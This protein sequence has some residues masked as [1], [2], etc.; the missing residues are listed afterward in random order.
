MKVGDIMKMGSDNSIVLSG[1]T[2]EQT[3]FEMCRK[4]VGGVSVVDKN[5]KLL[6]IFTDGDLRRCLQ[7]HGGMLSEEII[8]NL[9]MRNPITLNCNQLIW[10]AINETISKHSVS[11]FPV[12]D[13]NEKIVGTLCMIDV[14]KS[15]L[16]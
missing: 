2:L 4:P 13:D 8:D 5:G 12:V 16:M 3:I 14:V 11:M 7:K 15:G 1:S 9:M 10:D 6:G